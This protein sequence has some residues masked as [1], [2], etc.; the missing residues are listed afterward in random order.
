MDFVK[1]K[2][3][4]KPIKK[5]LL[6]NGGSVQ[7]VMG[8]KTRLLTHDFTNRPLHTLPWPLKLL[9]P[10]SIEYA[11]YEGKTLVEE[12]TFTRREVNNAISL[13]LDGLSADDQIILNPEEGSPST[14]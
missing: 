2:D 11:V 14:I 8:N 4:K 13:F 5:M 1:A 12:K 3:S 9:Q 10:H 6:G 7:I